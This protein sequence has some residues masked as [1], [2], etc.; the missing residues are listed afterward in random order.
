[1][2]K[3]R[4]NPSKTQISEFLTRY[5]FGDNIINFSLGENASIYLQDK[6]TGTHSN[7][8][9]LPEMKK[10]RFEFIS[11]TFQNRYLYF[12]LGYLFTGNKNETV[13]DFYK[14]DVITNEWI[15]MS[16]FPF[17]WVSGG[18]GFEYQ[19]NLVFVTSPS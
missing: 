18:F 13:Q 16:D 10:R 4:S 8:S 15:R 6:L 2:E 7:L 9:D 11:A 3:Y 17:D 19:G 12:G 1:M 14:L 5:N